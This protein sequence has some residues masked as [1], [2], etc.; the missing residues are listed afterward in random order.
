MGNEHQASTRTS[1]L[2]WGVSCVLALAVSLGSVADAQDLESVRWQIAALT[3]SLG[4]DDVRGLSRDDLVAVTPEAA[5]IT[6][7][8]YVPEARAHQVPS[9]AVT[10]A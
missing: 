7:L 1:S 2:R 6:G 4:H 8:E 10:V 3:E 9:L 5:V